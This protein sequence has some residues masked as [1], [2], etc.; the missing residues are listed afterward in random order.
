VGFVGGAELSLLDLLTH[1]DRGRFSPEVV[2]LGEGEFVD[3]LAE[4]GIPTRISALP[5]SVQRLS[6]RGLRSGAGRLVAATP[7]V[8]GEAIGLAAYLRKTGAGLVH[9]NGTKAHVIGGLAGRLARLPVV[10]HVRDFLGAGRLEGA[11]FWL[12]SR[13]PARVVANS[14]AVARS[15][16]GQGFSP[17]RVVAVHNGVDVTQ[18][19]GRDGTAFRAA[20]G[21]PC[22]APLVGLIGML[23][24][25]KG[26]MEFLEAASLVLP[27]A[28]E[29]RFVIVGGEPYETDGHG[30]FSRSLERRVQELGLEGAVTLAGYRRDIP[31]VLAALDVVVHA[32]T[33]PEPF[34]R[35]LIEAMAARRP[36]VATDGG[37]V[38]EI[39]GDG[40]GG[41]VV[42]PGAGVPMA[43]AIL[44]LLR[45]PHRRALLAE[46]GWV[47]VHE[48]FTVQAHA[49]RIEQVYADILRRP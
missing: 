18:Y 41:L 2:C 3:R 34:G 36:L 42:P 33:A 25:W 16:W 38:R 23:T 27:S 35:V 24:P 5:R 39:L 43:E 45:D 13:I 14:Q 1:L 40:G 29:T 12:G 7:A 21:I 15:W 9:T 20:M 44:D 26:Q 22:N 6:L 11:L 37:A 48:C 46:R 49:R 47:R 30:G 17:T 28:P 10:W 8:L 32:S 19:Q 4:R 31:E